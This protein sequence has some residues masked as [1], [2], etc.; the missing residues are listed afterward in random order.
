MV[1]CQ[2]ERQTRGRVRGLGK[3]VVRARTGRP[4]AAS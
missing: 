3:P 2:A 1:A 4:T